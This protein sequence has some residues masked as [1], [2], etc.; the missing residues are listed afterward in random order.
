MLKRLT[1]MFS[2]IFILA[3]LSSAQVETGDSEVIFSGM[4]M[5]IVGID[6]Y[7]S[8]TA[9]LNLNYGY[10]LTKN[11]EI[12]FGPTVT[13]TRTK[14]TFTTFDFFQGE[15]EEEHIDE[16]TNVSGTVFINLNFAT[17]SKTVPYFAAQWFQ[18]DFNPKGEQKFSDFSYLN[19]GFGIRNFLN[20]YAAL[21]TS[22]NY[23]WSQAENAEGG[24]ILVLTGLSV[25]F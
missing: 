2:I 15:K 24:I 22:V 25:I 12:G 14:M 13:H 21:N 11:L 18:S 20:E 1:L 3:T 8:V 7:S 6:N 17:A 9:S 19:V 4:F 23:G 5:S 16:T 10:F